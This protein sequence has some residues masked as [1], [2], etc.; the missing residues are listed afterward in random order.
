[1]EFVKHNYFDEI[2][3]DSHTFFREYHLNNIKRQFDK[4]ETERMFFVKMFNIDS[5]MR[6]IFY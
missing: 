6:S 4:I 1:M 2:E 5:K 3:M